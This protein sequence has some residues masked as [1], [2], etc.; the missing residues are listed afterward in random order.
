MYLLIFSRVSNFRSL[1]LDLHLFSSSVP[2]SALSTLLSFPLLTI[3]L[4][5]SSLPSIHLLSPPFVLSSLLVCFLR[6]HDNSST[7]IS[8]TTLRLQTFR[9]QL[10]RLP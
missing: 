1:K 8:S 4:L 7:D 9:L 6:Y 3:P 2:L 10:F 5:T